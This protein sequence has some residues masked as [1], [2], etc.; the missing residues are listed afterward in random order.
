MCIKSSYFKVH[1]I[2]NWHIVYFFI[3][4]LIL[5]F[6]SVLDCFCFVVILSFESFIMYKGGHHTSIE[7]TKQL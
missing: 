4:L 5:I 1:N 3:T 6:V 7:I 2:I